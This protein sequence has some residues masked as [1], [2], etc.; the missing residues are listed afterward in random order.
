MTKR[1]T[2]SAMALALT[3]ICLYAAA[4][5]STGKL[6][7]L[8]LSSLFVCLCI[9]QFGVRYGIALYI[10]ASIISLL[11]IPNKMFVLLYILFAGYY[12]VMKLYIERL[13][14]MW[15]EWLLKVLTFNFILVV[16]YLVFRIFFLPALTSALTGLVLQ[17]LGLIIVGLEILFVFYDWILSYMIGYYHQF[18]RRISHE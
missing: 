13:N 4:T 11:L 6:V 5:L 1:V 16:I 9:S 18:L 15:A 10:G 12:P 17:Y 8:G 3:V 7:A 2:F 14:K